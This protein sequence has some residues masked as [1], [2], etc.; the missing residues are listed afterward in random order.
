MRSLIQILM[1]SLVRTY[2]EAN[3]GFFLVVLYLAFGLLR[4][5]EHIALATAISTSWPLTLLTL[6]LWAVYALK[7]NAFVFKIFQIKPYRVVRDL[8]FYPSQA[9]WIGLSTVHFMLLLPAWAYGLF[10]SYFAIVQVH[11]AHLVTLV[12]F[13]TVLTLSSVVFTIQLIKKPAYETKPGLWH[14]WISQRWVLPRY[15]W[16][17]RYVFIHEPL[18]AFLAKLG[19]LVILAGSFYLYQTDTYDW[20]LLGVGTVFA[21]AFN[22]MLVYGHYAFNQHNSWTL[23]IPLQRTQILLSSFETWVVLFIPEMVVLFFNAWGFIPIINLFSL[24]L[25]MVAL[26]FFWTGLLTRFAISREDYGKQSFYL[27][28]VLVVMIMYAVPLMLTSVILMTIGIW[29]LSAVY[30]LK[31]N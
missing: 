2:Y 22:T 26:A 1:R 29:S 25:F 17:V 27:V 31:A 12:L 9:Q 30:L 28:L 20:R 6:A 5:T 4:T 14:L 24:C 7:T 8:A 18:P 10:I 23:N 15:L 21:Y 11:Y 19:S 3:V 13:L 16:Y